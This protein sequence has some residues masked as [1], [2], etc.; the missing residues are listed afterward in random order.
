MPRAMQYWWVTANASK[1]FDY[2]DWEKFFMP[3]TFHSTT[4]GMGVA[5]LVGYA[6]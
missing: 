6:T 4:V 1:E 2:W 5:S 3:L